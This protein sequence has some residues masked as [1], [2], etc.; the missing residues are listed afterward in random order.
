[1]TY[2]SAAQDLTL[3]GVRVLGFPATARIVGRYGLDP[4][5]TEEWLLDFEAR[6]WVR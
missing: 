5:A 4:Q 2:R 1:M 3:H 6:G